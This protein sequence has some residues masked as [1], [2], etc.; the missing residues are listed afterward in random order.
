MLIPWDPVH[1]G[2]PGGERLV[3]GTEREA[4]DKLNEQARTKI[5]EM[6]GIFSEEENQR[7]MNEYYKYEDGHFYTKL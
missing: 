5:M 6:V 4:V 2:A 3:V 7:I 1:V